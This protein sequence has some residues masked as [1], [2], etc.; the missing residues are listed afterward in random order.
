MTAQTLYEKLWNSHLVADRDD[1]SSLLYI[2]RQMIHEVTSPQ[3]FDGLR[4]A[5]RA[6]WRAAAH[7]ATAD[8]IVPT[9]AAQLRD[10]V[11]SIRDPLAQTQLRALDLNCAEFGIDLYGLGDDRR[12]IV[13]VIGPELGLSLPGATMVCGDSHTSTHGALAILAMGI[14][15]SQIEHVLA[16]QCIVTRR[17][18]T[19]R[20]AFDGRPP[21]GVGAK[22]MV[23]AL[24]GRIGA[25]GAAGCAIEFVG[26][27]VRALPMSA[28]MTLCNMSIEAGAQVGMVAVDDTTLDYLRERPLAPKGDMWERAQAAWRALR[29][30]D[31]AVFEHSARMDVSA[32]PPQVTWGTSPDMVCGVDGAVPAPD[33]A[34]DAT[35]ERVR[36]ALDY[37]GLQPGMPITD[38]AVDEVFIGSCTN[39]RLDDLR[40][41]AEV[42]RGR[43]VSANLRRALVVPGSERVKAAAEREGL[44]RIFIDAGMTWREPGCSMCLGMNDDRLGP[45]ARCAATSNRNFQGR[46]G[47]LGRTHLVSPA[48][49][50]AAAVAGHFVDVREW[51]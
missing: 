46:Q 22:D 8:H 43:R 14:G 2:D 31:G 23:L 33:S 36:S 24:I 3:A 51:F 38:I 50:A 9:D 45:R 30:D 5:G 13:H 40:T 27:A 10:G 48:M 17:L 49:A 19:M 7:V 34:P 4:A 12:G 32:L 20:V 47:H 18:E 6:P 25:A 29:S 11:D 28:R 42:V 1:G 15:T 44:D 16:T 41:A 21:P 26:E 35:G 37:M 39:S